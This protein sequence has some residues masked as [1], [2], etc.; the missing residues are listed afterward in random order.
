MGGVGALLALLLLELAAMGSEYLR[1]GTIRVLGRPLG[2]YAGENKEGQRLRPGVRLDGLGH[3]LAVNSLGFRGP[4]LSAVKGP[5]T[6]RVW[7]A[8]GSTTFDICVSSDADAWPAQLQRRLAAASPGVQIEVINAGIPGEVLA[9]NLRDFQR[10]ARRLDP[11]VLVIYPGPNDLRRLANEKFGHEKFQASWFSELALVRVIGDL[12]PPPPPPPG[13][14]ANLLGPAD[15]ARF[16]LQVQPLIDAARRRGTRVVLASHG[17]AAANDATADDALSRLGR[18]ARTYRMT[19]L[20]LVAAYRSANE[21]LRQMAARQGLAFVDLRAAV[22][23]APDRWADGIHFSD[24][25]AAVAGK[26]VAEA[27]VKAGLHRPRTAANP[28]QGR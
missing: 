5:T 8:G 24:R 28:G 21:R 9:T 25:G 14:A 1:H 15:M 10:L 26:A 20:G 12:L 4:E 17:F 7:C 6:L 3:A 18:N 13:W 11:D 16:E 23:S 22:G 27:M 2:L 19:P